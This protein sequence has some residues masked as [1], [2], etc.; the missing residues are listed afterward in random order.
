M[1]KV[2][3]ID[4]EEPSR[5]AIRILGEWDK[6]GVSDIAEA[7]GGMAGI[8]YIKAHRPNI[9]LVDMKMPEITGV[10]VLQWIEKEH[11]DIFTIV[12]SGYNDFEFTRQAIKSKAVDYLLKPVNRNDLNQALFKASEVIEQ[13]RKQ[14]DESISRNIALNMSLPKLKETIFLSIIERKFNEQTGAGDL[15]MIGAEDPARWFGTAIVRI[16]N[17]DAV[18]KAR[19]KLDTALLYFA[20]T[21]VINEI[22]SKGLE[23]FSFA[24]PKLDREV[25]VIFTYAGDYREGFQ[26][27]S[28]PAVRKVL[29]KLK[30]LFGVI[31]VGGIG[32]PCRGAIRLGDSYRSAGQAVHSV[33]LFETGDVLVSSSAQKDGAEVHAM[34]NRIAMIRSA[35]QEGNF[36]Y[37][38]SILGDFIGNV[39]KSGSFP[40]GDAIRTLSEFDILLRD[41]ALELGAPQHGLDKGEYSLKAR[42]ELHDFT[43]FDEVEKLLYGILEEYGDRIRRSVKTRGGFHIQDIREHID[44]HYFEDIKISLFTE[45]Y[46]LSR[47]YLM[48][49]FKQEYGMGIYE[50]VQKVRMEKARELLGNP[51]LQIQNISEMLGYNDKNYFS[52]A[53]KNYYSLS[54]REYRSSQLQRQETESTGQS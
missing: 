22:G 11:P 4:D 53:F 13:N 20:L 38:A 36:T 27:Q 40:L 25:V 29:R 48:K 54:P 10:E 21:N 9:V 26:Q 18:R 12:I 47:E 31:A 16:M 5:E 37:A 30:E 39:K 15:K 6:L 52:K 7:S 17:L 3:I 45:K 35:L 49:L 43:S 19:F 42:G 44:Q 34:T 8:E 1:Y 33:D 32:E 24:N 2:L 41:I 50:Y 28:V 23:C 14:R 51:K 46:F